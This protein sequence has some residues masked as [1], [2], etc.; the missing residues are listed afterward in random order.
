M[1]TNCFLSSIVSMFD[2][3]EYQFSFGHICICVYFP[4]SEKDRLIGSYDRNQICLPFLWCKIN[5]CIFQTSSIAT[6]MLVVENIRNQTKA[7]TSNLT[8]NII[9][10]SHH[11]PHWKGSCTAAASKSQGA[12]AFYSS[13]VCGP[14]TTV[15]LQKHF[16]NKYTVPCDTRRMYK[17]LK[18]N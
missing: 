12:H 10:L 15:Y 1:E 13:D 6:Q 8:S 9:K 18:R 5:M 14:S 17:V 11:F 16:I 4:L 2:V 3:L 7:K